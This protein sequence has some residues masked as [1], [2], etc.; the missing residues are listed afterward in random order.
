VEPAEFFENCGIAFARA[1]KKCGHDDLW[2]T[3]GDRLVRLRFAGKG[4]RE[5]MEPSFCHLRV[6][7]DQDDKPRAALTVMIWDYRETGEA[8]PPRPWPRE[9]EGVFGRVA[10]FGA[11]RFAAMADPDGTQ[12]WM[13]DRERCAAIF[14]VRDVTCLESWDRIHPLRQLLGAWADTQDLQMVH[15]GA[16]GT[17]N[18]GILVV[19]PGGSGKSTTVLATLAAGGRAAGDDYVLIGGG[20][21]PVAYSV[22]GAMRLFESHRTR[23]PYLMAH[24]DATTPGADGTPKL[25][26]Y[27]SVHRPE[28]MVARL[29]ISAIVMPHPAP[30]GRTRAWREAGGRALFALA[31]STLKQLDPQSARA[32]ARMAALCRALPCWSLDLGDDI[33]TVA[34]MID[35]IVAKAAAA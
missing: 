34:P 29:P 24:P 19:G 21:K 9:A 3:L 17:S 32:L 33:D 6:T 1:A 35:D 18:G 13:H 25:T 23:F 2:L 31:P 28:V 20:D 7:P 26:S 8:I 4:P 16:V 10:E 14:W 11:P 22:Y 5:F 12:V 30:G 27:I 15:A